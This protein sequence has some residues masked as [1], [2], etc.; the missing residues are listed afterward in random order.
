MISWKDNVGT[1]RAAVGTNSN[2]YA[3]SRIGTVYD[4]T[5]SGFTVGR[6]DAIAGSGYGS[7]P[8]GTAAYGAPRAD[9]TITEDA[10]IWSLDT[11]GEDLVGVMAEDGKIYE[12]DLNTAAGAVVITNAPTAR[13]ILTTE[14]GILF[15]LGAAGNPR[16]VAWSDQRNNTVWTP[17]ATN[18]AGDFDLQTSGRLMLGKKAPSGVSLLLT[19]LDA[20]TATYTADTL[21]YSFKKIG[22]GCGAI[23]QN[24]AV[25][26]DNSIYWMSESGFW[27]FAGYVEP[28]SCDVT[29]Y[30]FSDIDP[31]Q[32]SKTTCSVDATFGEVTWRYQSIGSLTGD[33]DKYVTLS[34]R[35]AQLTVN[36]LSSA[37]TFHFGSMS[38]LCGTDAGVMQRPMAV[39]ND[40][41]VYNHET[42]FLYDGAVPYLEG[43]PVELGNGDNTFDVNG[44]IPDEKTAGDVQVSFTAKYEPEDAPV[45]YGPY[46][47]ASKQD[48]RFSAR[49]VNPRFTGVT[50]SDWRI[51]INRL[52][53]EQAGER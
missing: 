50:A 34:T 29:D 51:G 32:V 23:S 7:G 37:G 9:P 12:W 49:Q 48:F 15:A 45:S 35:A 43:G 31:D 6:P 1:G 5:P 47:A 38:R 21:V 2:L 33:V 30:I 25:A 27:K 53:V 4:I 11:W 28:I 41:I 16:N 42:G 19:D 52:I 13:A 20:H 8:Y 3:M 14:Q 40:G 17:D 24:A 26:F 18:Q 36:A 44:M 46:A 10:S 39:G 22:D